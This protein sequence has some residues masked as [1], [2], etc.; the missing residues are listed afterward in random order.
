MARGLELLAGDGVAGARALELGAHELLGADVGVGDRRQVGLG[1]DLQVGCA[2]A[3][4]RQPVD[5]VGDHVRQAEVVVVGGHV[6]QPT[7]TE[8]VVTVVDMAATPPDGLSREQQAVLRAFVD[9]DGRLRRIPAR[10]AKR[11]VVLDRIVQVF[12]VG[13]RYTELEVNALLRAFHDDVAALRR[14]L[15][16]EGFLSRE[17]GVYWRTGGTVLFDD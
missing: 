1:V 5:L 3:V 12:E 2:E 9:D 17:Q 13:E 16:D 8:P 4:H 14:H 7:V 11:L 10:R 6:R 15:V